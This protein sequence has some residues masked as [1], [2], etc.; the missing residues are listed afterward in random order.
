MFSVVVAL[1]I[2]VPPRLR[3]PVAVAG[4]TLA[5]LTALAT[6]S[7]GW[8]RAGDSIAAF[9]NVG[10]WAGVASVMMVLA[11]R[12]A[13]PAEVPPPLADPWRRRLLRTVLVS[14][15]VGLGLG[16]VLAL[17]GPLRTSSVGAVLAFLAGGVLVVVAGA[18]VLVAELFVLDRSTFT[19]RT[20][21]ER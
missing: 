9:L 7:A 5:V 2:V 15:A 3:R 6:M 10:F 4:G 16:L 20:V 17:V 14:A 1:L 11:A 19:P 12:D 13:P 18:S 8:H 21:S